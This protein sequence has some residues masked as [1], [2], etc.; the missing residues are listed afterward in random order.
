MSITIEIIPKQFLNIYPGFPLH[1]IDCGAPPWQNKSRHT[2]RIKFKKK[3]NLERLTKEGNNEIMISR[4]NNKKNICLAL[5]P[6]R[7]MYTLRMMRASKGIL[8]L[9]L[10]MSSPRGIRSWWWS[11]LKKFEGIRE[12]DGGERRRR[13][14]A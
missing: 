7:K 14:E 2:F 10:G 11:G 5:R 6:W 12:P 4:F 1:V 9:G 13:V 8:G 3:L